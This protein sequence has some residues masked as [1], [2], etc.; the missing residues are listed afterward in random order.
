MSAKVDS[1]KAINRAGW[2]LLVLFSAITFLSSRFAL[3]SE[4]K[5]R[6]I[7]AVFALF[8]VAFG[9]YLYA[10]RK[11]TN[12]KTELSVRKILF[13]SVVFRVVTLFSTPILE[14]DVYRYIWD[15]NVVAAG[16]NPYE[17]APKEVLDANEKSPPDL[18]QLSGLSKSSSALQTI[19]ETVHFGN[20]PSPYPPVSQAVFATAALLTP[21]SAAAETHLRVMRFLIVLFDVG[22]LW[23]L[24]LIL[25]HLGKSLEWAIAYGWCP[26]V[27][28]E[29]ANSGHL[30]S[31]TV[32]FTVAAAYALIRLGTK[33]MWVSAVLL[34]CATAG[35]FFPLVLVPVFVTAWLRMGDGETRWK[36]GVLA[37]TTYCIAT[38]AL[39]V[40]MFMDVSPPEEFVKGDKSTDGFHAFVRYWEMNDF[41][42]MITIENLKPA[43]LSRASHPPW[44]TVVSD[45]TRVAIVNAGESRGLPPREVPFLLARLITA[46]I[47]G[48]IILWTAGRLW[49]QRSAERLLRACFTSLAWLWLL[50]P[51]QNPWYWTWSLAFIPFAGRRGWLWVSGLAM[52]YYLRFWFEY[53]YTGRPVF[54]TQ[55]QGTEFFDYVVTCVEFGPWLL[56]MLVMA[57]VGRR[58]LDG[59]ESV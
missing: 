29:F 13:F 7:L 31:I 24:I 17:F 20:L 5:Q 52:M 51:T 30:D 46:S 37:L 6:P 12:G 35:K 23:V 16:V 18:K 9:V 2:A 59:R 19:L 11:A 26:L 50:A 54:G 41:L 49:H 25:K 28:K 32:F 57:L 47:Y 33:A 21:D 4:P 45:S 55:Y 36:Q 10:V 39:L 15:G 22:T 8:T 38:A 42:F 48:L 44:F 34:A 14:I 43:E 40:P 56:F 53:H 27:L 3:G 58:S 1:S